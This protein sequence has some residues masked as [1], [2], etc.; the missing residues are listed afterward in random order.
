MAFIRYLACNCDQVHR[1]LP[2]TADESAFRNGLGALQAVV[3]EDLVGTSPECTLEGAVVAKTNGT[4]EHDLD[5]CAL[6]SASPVDA[7]D[8]LPF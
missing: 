4:I 1:R 3:A 8:D 2:K 7:D 5:G 6:R